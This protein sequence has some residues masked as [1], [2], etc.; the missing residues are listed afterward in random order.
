MTGVYLKRKP[1]PRKIK[2][3]NNFIPKCETILDFGCGNG[4][5][6]QTLKLKC[7]NLIGIDLNKKLLDKCASLKIYQSLLQEKC[8]PI[9]YFDNA[10]DVFFASEVI[11]HL[12]ELEP[13]MIEI[14]RVTFQKI[15][16]TMPNPLYSYFYNDPTHVL[17]YSVSSLLNYLNKSKKFSYKIKGL[18]FE[19]VPLP[20]FLKKINQALLWNFPKIS[21][22]IAVLGEKN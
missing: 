13:I 2:L 16:L 1:E 22:T 21:P 12:S 4:L 5:Y 17:K 6:A 15:L 14:E 10:I 9:N 7:N 11:E 19:N 3:I 20:S 18:G 8:P